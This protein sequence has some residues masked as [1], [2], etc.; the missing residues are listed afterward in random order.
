[1]NKNNE[2]FQKW[3]AQSHRNQ[4]IQNIE[5]Y[6]ETSHCAQLLSILDQK[7]IVLSE[8]A[9]LDC[10]L[11]QQGCI[12]E[13]SL[14]MQGTKEHFGI[15]CLRFIWKTRFC[16]LSLKLP[17]HTIALNISF[18]LKRNGLQLQKHL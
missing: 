16:S 4:A 9:L 11:F 12:I 10:S 5:K 2:L 13:L 14:T 1:M 18:L 8:D 15:G 7:K 17:N 3:L 6:R